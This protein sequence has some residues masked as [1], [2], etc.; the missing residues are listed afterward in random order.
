M[1]IQNN[2][3]TISRLLDS[4]EP[5]HAQV[6]AANVG[7]ADRTA[8]ICRERQVRVFEI[9]NPTDMGR[10][11]NKLISASRHDWNFWIEPWEVLTD[12]RPVIRALETPPA[13]YQFMVL[14]GEVATY[15]V[16]LWHK[17]L[18]LKFKNPVCEHLDI[19]EQEVKDLN[20]SIYK[21]GSKELSLEAIQEWQKVHPASPE[22]YYY[23]AFYH[24]SHQ[25]WEAFTNKATVYL[26]DRNNA[27][28]ST[29]MMKYYLAIVL[30]HIQHDARAAM[31]Q[32]VEC[33]IVKPLSAECW[34]LLGDV[35]YHLSRDYKKAVQFYKNALLL[36]SCRLKEETMPMEISKYQEYPRKMIA[37]CK[38]VLESG[39]EVVAIPT[40]H[41]SSSG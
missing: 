28:Q 5:L 15:E 26:F 35:F 38:S 4:L 2:E 12:A 13:A 21:D 39:S 30:C 6:M 19:Q 24:L 17:D 37:A 7:C 11:R 20:C 10:V 14:G 1:V 32:I 22:P 29:L 8:D 9:T 33:L 41:R 40:G 34:C 18:G 27:T 3:A 31:K 23:E 16:R 25:N 36:G